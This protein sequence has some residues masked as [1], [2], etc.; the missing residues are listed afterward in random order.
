MSFKSKQNWEYLM[1]KPFIGVTSYRIKHPTKS[2]NYMGMTE[3]YVEAI[4]EAGALPLLIPVGISNEDLDAIHQKVDGVLFTGGGDVSPGIYKGKDHPAIAGVDPDRD[5]IEMHLVKQ[6]IANKT[7]FLGICRGLQVINVALGGTLYTDVYDQHPNAQ[8]HNYW[9]DYPRDQISHPIQVS[10]GTHLSKILN[11][12]IVEVNSLHHQ[13]IL[14]MAPGLTANAHAPDGLIEGIELE[15]YPY[16]VAVQWHPE[17]LPATH[18][19]P[20]L[21][22]S[23]IKAALNGQNGE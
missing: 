11:Q 20:E 23:F 22:R 6:V 3:A 18:R 15:E 5:R 4:Y 8:M 17:W 21:F 10:E 7:P 1:T 9:P 12:S 2:W 14:D 16:G 13:G 19:Q